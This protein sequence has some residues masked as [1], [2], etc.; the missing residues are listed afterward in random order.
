MIDFAA[1]RSMTFAT[2]TYIRLG[3]RVEIALED[4]ALVLR[5]GLAADTAGAVEATPSLTGKLTQLFAECGVCNWK[6]NYKPEGYVVYDGE[7]WE[8]S[9]T[10][11]YGSVFES[12]WSNA[13][14]EEFGAFWDGLC[15]ILGAGGGWVDPFGREGE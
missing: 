10:F 3:S 15:S 14:P 7:G 6:R 5:R 12:S 11:E 9:L 1:V 8:L 4:G 2:F 13:W